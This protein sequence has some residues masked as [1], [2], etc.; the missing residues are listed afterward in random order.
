[1]AKYYMEGDLFYI[2]AVSDGTTGEQ[3]IVRLE[4]IGYRVSEYAKELL[5]SEDF[6]PTSGKTYRIAVLPGRLFSDY[7]RTTSNIREE[8]VRR[9]LETPNPEV[10]CLLR[11][12]LSNYDIEAMGLRKIAVM[13]ERVE[14]SHGRQAFLGLDRDDDGGVGRWLAAN[15]G[16]PCLRWHSGRGFA[17]VVPQASPN[18]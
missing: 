13:H 17:F 5:R 7:D 15:L 14:D 16:M 18:R 1:M 6:V 9:G 3:W 4:W 11:V 10:A 2:E 12:L 8:A